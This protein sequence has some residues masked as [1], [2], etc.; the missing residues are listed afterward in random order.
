MWGG[1]CGNVGVHFGT[2]LAYYEKVLRRYMYVVP[3]RPKS[4]SLRLQLST[5]LRCYNNKRSVFVVFGNDV[6]VWYVCSSVWN[7]FG[8]ILGLFS[9]T[10]TA[11]LQGVVPHRLVVQNK[12]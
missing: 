2:H 10:G 11:V 5:Q 9:T 12:E 7:A 6:Y 1:V 3:G 4:P 8:S